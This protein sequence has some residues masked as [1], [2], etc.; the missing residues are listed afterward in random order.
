MKTQ[1]LVDASSYND[2]HT[3]YPQLELQKNSDTNFLKIHSPLSPFNQLDDD[4]SFLFQHFLTNTSFAVVAFPSKQRNIYLNTIVPMSMSQPAIWYSLLSLSAEHCK[5]TIPK[6]HNILR[7]FHHQAIRHSYE[8]MATRHKHPEVVLSICLMLINNE[9]AL[10]KLQKRSSLMD[11]ASSIIKSNGGIQDF[12]RRSKNARGLIELFIYHD[13][14]SSLTTGIPGLSGQDDSNPFRVQRKVHDE[15]ESEPDLFFGFA[16][17]LFS[18]IIKLPSFSCYN[19]LSKD[20]SINDQ[21][22][23]EAI[24]MA[25]QSWQLPKEINDLLEQAKIKNLSEIENDG[26]DL[27]SLAESAIAIQWAGILMHHQMRNGY[28]L[29]N[30]KVKV[31]SQNIVEAISHIR[32]GSSLESLILFPLIMAALGGGD[33]SF[34]LARFSSISS[35]LGFD[36]I[37]TAVRFVREVWHNSDNGFYYN[38]NDK[39]F[40]WQRLLKEKYCHLSMV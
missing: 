33:R 9:I 14:M 6:F 28:A 18:H 1:N 39:G 12:K 20:F 19:S 17:D 8:Y 10:N 25:L 11:L 23:Y 32:M 16:K 24:E 4:E 7:Q 27:L 36:H 15:S 26:T 22:E 37:N 34:I 31:A 30:P 35:N 21:V 5:S 29:D 38:S 3:H 13:V 2:T 40:N